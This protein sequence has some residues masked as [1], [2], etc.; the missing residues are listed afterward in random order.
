M[1]IKFTNH[2]H[3]SYSVELLGS[4]G[5]VYAQGT[6]EITL[7]PAADGSQLLIQDDMASHLGTIFLTGSHNYVQGL[8][9]AQ[10]LSA[11][12]GVHVFSDAFGVN[13]R[14]A[15]DEGPPSGVI[16]ASESINVVGDAAS[17]VIFRDVKLSVLGT[18]AVSFLRMYRDGPN[19]PDAG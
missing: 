1:S 19:L 12:P 2:T 17:P 11:G 5:S 8:C 3:R 15:G 7:D 13:S 6:G 14:H 10:S 18:G 9:I 4:E 16:V